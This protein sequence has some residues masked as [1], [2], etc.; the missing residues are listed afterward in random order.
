MKRLSDKLVVFGTHD[1]NTIQ[2][3]S[4]V[5]TRVEHMVLS[6]DGHYGYSYPVGGIAALRNHVSLCGVGVDV[7][8][9]V[10]AIRTDVTLE[11]LGDRR[12][13]EALADEMARTLAFGTG[14]SN[15]AD[16]APVSHPLFESAAWDGIPDIPVTSGKRQVSSIR[17]ALRANARRQLG[18]IGGGN[19]F[20]NGMVDEQGRI[21]V[22]A[23]F[24][25]RGLGHTVATNYMAFGQGLGWG[26]RL[27][28]GAD[29]LLD[30]DTPLGQ[31]YWA[32]MELCGEYAYAGRDW[33]VRKVAS[34]FGG[35]E[36]ERVHQHHNAAWRE[37][38][39]IGRGPEELIV[40]R[41]GAT[42][43]FPG[44]LGAVGG[45]MGD[46]SVIL[47][48][49]TAAPRRHVRRGD[50][51]HRRAASV[52]LLNRAWRRTRD[53]PHRSRGQAAPEDGRVAYGRRRLPCDDARLAGGEG[54]HP[55]WRRPR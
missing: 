21:W 2:Q 9:G 23:H 49:T 7:A 14:R 40:V 19:H 4:E 50:A 16:D 11:Q 44:Q 8:C 52:T 47:E 31:D 36:V 42:P 32:L 15:A 22:M 35:A 26:V 6:A 1:D 55:A 20:V 54:R 53:V 29:V 24:G 12:A 48:G 10:A 13:L 37:V 43:A 5:A 34:L 41:K 38:H 46:D 18:T 25:S 3:A 17:E 45:S 39:D 51:A 33:V 30:L 27:N 28:E